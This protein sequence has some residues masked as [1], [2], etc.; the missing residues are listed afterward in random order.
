MHVDEQLTWGPL[1]T[2]VSNRKTVEIFWVVDALTPKR[3][4]T[5]VTPAEGALCWT[6]SFD[7]LLSSVEFAATRC[8]ASTSESLLLLKT[9]LPP[10]L[11]P[12][13]IPL[14]PFATIIC[15]LSSPP[16]LVI[17]TFAA[18]FTPDLAWERAAASSRCSSTLQSN[19]VRSEEEKAK[20]SSS[21]GSSDV[22]ASSP[23]L[24][25]TFV[26]VAAAD[27]DPVTKELLL[28]P[29]AV[30]STNSILGDR[31]GGG[32]GGGA[33]GGGLCRQGEYGDVR[34]TRH[35]GLLGPLPLEEA[36]PV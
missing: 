16:G 30:A 10:R 11:T 15:L 31:G 28:T 29:P 27:P 21:S 20:Q 4:F 6:A 34:V 19:L 24:E 23:L 22:H 2:F 18:P 12:G 17:C 35:R 3:L 36:V 7:V 1:C 14:L 5:Q 8:C 25:L 26:V 13:R 9:S 32:D 33:G